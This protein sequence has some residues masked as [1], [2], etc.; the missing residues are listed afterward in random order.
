M[1]H[2]S[3]SSA[4]AVAV[5]TPCSAVTGPAVTMSLSDGE[6]RGSGVL[7]RI[8]LAVDV[9]V[10]REGKNVAVAIPSQVEAPG[11]TGERDGV[12]MLRM[13][14]NGF[15]GS[16]SNLCTHSSGTRGLHDL[17]AVAF[18]AEGQV[19]GQTRREPIT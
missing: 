4:H 5:A 1:T 2:S 15:V 3:P 19:V 7:R 11:A 17:V 13:D 14:L 12:G 18:D 9:A 8:A 10:D 16:S 6:L